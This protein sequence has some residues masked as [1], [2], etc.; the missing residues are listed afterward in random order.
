MGWL[1]GFWVF[2][3]GYVWLK[4]LSFGFRVQR[5]RLRVDKGLVRFVRV[6]GLCSALR[7]EPAF[8]RSL[9]LG[10]GFTVKVKVNKCS[11][12]RYVIGF[13]ACVGLAHDP[14]PL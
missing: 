7:F 1:W 8:R 6:D 3:F 12:L 2:G 4:L 5:E 14:G 9:G 10:V 11:L 13:M